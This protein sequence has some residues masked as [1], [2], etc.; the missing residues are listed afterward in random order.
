MKIFF[1]SFITFKILFISF[2]LFWGAKPSEAVPSLDHKQKPADLWY[3]INWSSQTNFLKRYEWIGYPNYY[4][5]GIA[6]NFQ[7]LQEDI[8]NTPTSLL[9][10]T[11]FNFYVC[12]F[13]EWKSKITYGKFD[14][15][16]PNLLMCP[17]NN[18]I[19]GFQTY[20]T[21][22]EKIT[23]I[24]SDISRFRILCSPSLRFMTFEDQE[25]NDPITIFKNELICGYDVGSRNIEYSPE[26][27]N[28]ILRNFADGMK[29]KLCKSP[30][31][32][33]IVEEYWKN[34]GGGIY[35]RWL[36]PFA[37]S[38]RFL[39]HYGCGINLRLLS[40]QGTGFMEGN[41]DAPIQGIS[42]LTCNLNNWHDQ[43]E[44]LL[45]NGARGNWLGKNSKTMCPFNEFITGMQIRSDFS[46]MG[47]DTL[48]ITGIRIKCGGYL[49]FLATNWITLETGFEKGIWREKKYFFGGVC[50]AMIKWHK[51]KG[52]GTTTEE[53]D[54]AL[55]GVKIKV[56][57]QLN[58]KHKWAKVFQR[59]EEGNVTKIE[60][61]KDYYGC[62]LTLFT[63]RLNTPYGFLNPVLPMQIYVVAC[64]L[65]EWSKQI[66]KKYSKNTNYVETKTICPQNEFIVGIERYM[67]ESNEVKDDEFK[68]DFFRIRIVC[69]PSMKVFDVYSGNGNLQSMFFLPK[70]DDTTIYFNNYLITGFSCSFY[71][72]DY[73]LKMYTKKIKNVLSSLSFQLSPYSLENIYSHSQKDSWKSIDE[74]E[75]EEGDWEEIT[76]WSDLKYSKGYIFG[77]IE[78]LFLSCLK[79]KAVDL[80][81]KIDKMF[82]ILEEPNGPLI[83]CHSGQYICGFQFQ[84]SLL[85]GYKMIVG[86]NVH[87]DFVDGDNRYNA[88]STFH[89]ATGI[90]SNWE[91]RQFLI[92]GG[93]KAF[94]CGMAVK[95]KEIAY[96]NKKFRAIIDLDLRMCS[97]DQ[98][99]N[100]VTQKLLKLEGKPE[101][102]WMKLMDWNQENPNYY[103]CGIRF[104]RKQILDSLMKSIDGI[105]F[106]LCNKNKYTQNQIWGKLDSSYEGQWEES[107]DCPDEKFIAGIQLKFRDLDPNL[108]FDSIS[109][110]EIKNKKKG[111]IIALRILCRERMKNFNGE[112]WTNIF[113]DTKGIWGT[114]YYFEDKLLMCGGQA[115][116]LDGKL[117][118]IQI[119]SCVE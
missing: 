119:K 89:Q 80:L 61:S 68:N 88:W 54:S 74:I 107:I 63:Q 1:F 8:S 113:A 32:Q 40:P 102:E 73:S 76:D 10:P 50:G 104:S 20:F 11:A 90:T 9:I 52:T 13:D 97:E 12:K 75:A 44:I 41:D 27:S 5:C 103:A 26:I 30:I 56:C 86:I 71:D 16:D 83:T 84:R 23:S 91:D 114:R 60:W 7:E 109:E 70:P 22:A 108:N 35:G 28:N 34:I 59:N 87:S 95:T 94:L 72:I 64:K 105:E 51:D 3:S 69:G 78:N 24:K 77:F 112:K 118:G 82:I 38:D 48:G 85:L 14:M 29:V 110:K 31:N 43:N 37:W 15:E 58:T 93:K 92:Y 57:P 49:D 98:Q 67:K 106:K 46:A 36:K 19:I 18:F 111:E 45:K 96:K 115:K 4:A 2:G 55:N 99:T 6:F 33:K 66:T 53:D 79:I 17:E 65:N 117:S 116:K 21:E 47:L 62:G 81:K 39:D 25:N 100:E 42:I 101:G